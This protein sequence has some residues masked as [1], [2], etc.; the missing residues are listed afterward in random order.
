M[1][2]SSASSVASNGGFSESVK[3]EAKRLTDDKCWNSLRENRPELD[4]R[5]RE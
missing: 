1:T 5:Q 2:I 4:L 3:L